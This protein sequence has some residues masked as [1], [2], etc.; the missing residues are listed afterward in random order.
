[1]SENVSPQ[2]PLRI[3]LK[4]DGMNCAVRDG[5]NIVAKLQALP[6]VRSANLLFPSRCISLHI[7]GPPESSSSVESSALHCI[8]LAGYAAAPR[9]PQWCALSLARVSCITVARRLESL[10]SNHPAVF[11]SCLDFAARRI[12]LLSDG[13]SGAAAAAAADAG[14]LLR[15]AS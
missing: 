14:L 5:S 8:Q 11:R 2:K 6:G 13:D 12:F 7:E 10:L 1:M 4:V 9:C 3:L 15:R